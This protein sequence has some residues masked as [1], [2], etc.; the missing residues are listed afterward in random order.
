M[1]FP[2][3]HEAIPH[4]ERQ[5]FEWS[6]DWTARAEG[7]W[8]NDAHDRGR[9]TRYGVSSR[10]HPDVDLE[11]LTPEGAK[12]IFFWRYWRVA[13]CHTLPYPLCLAVFDYAV[14]SGAPRAV[15]A[16]QAAIGTKADGAFGPNSRKALAAALQEPGAEI[17]ALEVVRLRSYFLVDGFR[18]G[19]FSP[20]HPL[21][22]LRNFWDRTVQLAYAVGNAE[23]GAP[24]PLLE[25][26]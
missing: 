3:I 9:L 12:R 23:Q 15:M 19:R 2:P 5:R 21:R 17:I 26:A 6:H 7:G 25:A 13:Q 11:A 24:P 10:A 1:S 18:E 22:Y 14:H 16:L 4:G 8:A 20:L